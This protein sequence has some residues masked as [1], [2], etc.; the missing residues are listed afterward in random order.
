MQVV[1]KKFSTPLPQR[2]PFL[3]E[4]V[5]E[6]SL[7]HTPAP[8]PAAQ[9]KLRLTKRTDHRDSEKLGNLS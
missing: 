5:A 2:A 1:R 6:V 4:D 3:P 9:G 7:I 8:K